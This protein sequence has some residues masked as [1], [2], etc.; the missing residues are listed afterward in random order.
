MNSNPGSLDNTPRSDKVDSI[1]PNGQLTHRE[2]EIV[3]QAIKDLAKQFPVRDSTDIDQLVNSLKHSIKEVNAHL[4]NIYS[5]VQA[6]G[7][8][9]NKAWMTEEANRLFIQKLSRYSKDELHLLMVC[10]LSDLSV[11]EFI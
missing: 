8:E 1:K 10:V 3:R 4:N 9:H 2:K 11:K 6:K 7:G 5:A